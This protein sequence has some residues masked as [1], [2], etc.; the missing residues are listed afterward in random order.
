M[1]I[2]LHVHT[3]ERSACGQAPA[4]DQVRAAMAAGLDAI[5]FTDHHRL[6]PA[7]RLASL[8]A[9]HAP[10]CIFGG[11]ELSLDDEDFIVLGVPDVRLEARAWSYPALH[12]VVRAAGGFLA[13]AHPFRY[14]PDIRVDLEQYRPD[15]IEVYSH[16]TPPAAAARI[17][18]VAAQLGIH[19]LSNSDA[20]T[21]AALGTYYNVLARRPAN[22]RELIAM[23][24]AGQFSIH[25]TPLTNR[26]T[27]G[28]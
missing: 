11:I 22:E 27:H 13:L 4:A 20:H 9:T 21:T 15:A 7:E 6:A 5:V 1:N 14:H 23:L 28:R 24:K 26:T 18:A 3:Q 25:N 2:D 10:F 8:N 19:P 12:A 17:F 16:N